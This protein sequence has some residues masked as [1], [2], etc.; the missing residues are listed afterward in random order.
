VRAQQVGR[1]AETQV[2][3]QPAR[4][5]VGQVGE[6]SG[7]GAAQ[8]LLPQHDSVE[9]RMITQLP[10]RG[11][12]GCGVGR[13]A[14]TSNSTESTDKTG[15]PARTIQ[16]IF[17]KNATTAPSQTRRACAARC[18]AGRPACPRTAR[19]RAPQRLQVKG[20]RYAAVAQ[21]RQRRPLPGGAALVT[22]AAQARPSRQRQDPFT[23]FFAENALLSASPQRPGIFCK[24][25]DQR[26]T[27]HERP[28]RLV[29]LVTS[30]AQARPSRQRPTSRLKNA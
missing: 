17:C 8:F 23:A 14:H 16:G 27:T 10:R 28:P 19:P 20:G 26:A 5:G 21:R 29:G 12:F 13:A 4:F 6:L 9:Q 25:C 15:P 11:G 2:D 30:A 7:L 3:G 18:E 22:S 1:A 24:K